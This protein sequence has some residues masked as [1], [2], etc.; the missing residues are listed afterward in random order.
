MFEH[1]TRKAGL[2]LELDLAPTLPP[3]VRGD[4]ARL[5]QILINFLGNAVKFTRTGGIKVRA[6]VAG[7]VVGKVRLRFE[8]EDTGIG[9]APAVQQR[10]FQAFSQ[11]DS[12]TTRRFGGT[13]LGLSI[14]RRLVELMGGA[15]GVESVEGQGS[16]FWF[17]LPMPLGAAQVEAHPPDT[18]G[19][20]PPGLRILVVED[21]AINQKIAVRLLEKLGARV[22]VA[23]NG[24]EAIDALREASY[25]LV[26]M[27]CQMPVMDGF[28]ATARLRSGEVARLDGLPIIAMTA[29]AMKGDAERCL[30]AGMSDYMS[31]PIDARRLAALV[32]KWGQVGL[33]RR[34]G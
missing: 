29:N 6:A 21:N 11:G 19:P 25:D 17:E 8:V 14:C 22:D 24:L 23:G 5:R 30:A 2:K 4:P 34:A 9:I 27:D 28:E 12:S 13:G 26:F 32:A 3:Y 33:G 16:V 7:E 1:V 18:A 31:K 10:L 15:I 20:V